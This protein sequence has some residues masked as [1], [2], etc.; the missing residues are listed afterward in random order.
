MIVERELNEITWYVVSVRFPT[1]AMAKRT[2]E[3]V[4]EQAS[5]KGGKLD[6][7]WY[8]HGPSNDPGRFLTAVTHNR[9]SALWVNRA[10]RSCEPNGLPEDEQLAMIL[11]RLDVINE[12]RLVGAREGS[13]SMRRP[14]ERGGRLH[15]DGSIE[16]R[17]GHG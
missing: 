5:A 9:Q 7:G 14:E 10:L 17:V 6:L 1:P 15:P 2:W 12:L 13:Y 8:R 11:R 16:E 4:Q 3:K